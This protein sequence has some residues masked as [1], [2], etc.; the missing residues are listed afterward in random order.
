MKSKL[1]RC[2]RLQGR[3][4]KRLGEEKKG[5]KRTLAVSSQRTACQCRGLGF[6]PCSRKIPH[7]LEQLS[8]CA[9]N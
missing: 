6:H 2:V 5:V 3:S 9:A 7:A 8:L 1:L 4:E